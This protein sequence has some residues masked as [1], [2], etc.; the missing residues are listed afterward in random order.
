MREMDL[1][2]VDLNL[3][4]ALEALLEEKNVTRAAHRLGMSQPAASRALARLRS[5]FSDALLVDGPGGYVLSGRA[6]EL[7]P[8]LRRI[9]TNVSEML[10]ANAFVPATATGRVRLLMPDL[11]AVSLAPHLLVILAR[12]APSL[13]LDIVAPGANATE[14]LENGGADAMVALIDDAPPGIQRR[15]LYDET[16]V[17]LLRANHPALTEPLTLDRFLALDHIV[18]SV[19]GVG[20]VP[21]DE[22]L[23]RMGRM[24]RV[25]LR[26]PELLRGRRDRRP[27]G[28]RHDAAFQPGASGRQ[29]AALRGV[30]AARRPR[31]LHDEPRL[32]RPSAGR[33]TP[34]LAATRRRRGRR[35]DV[36]GARASRLSLFRRGRADG[37]GRSKARPFRSSAPNHQISGRSS[38]PAGRSSLMALSSLATCSKERSA[39]P[40]ERRPFS[41]RSI[42][43]RSDR[44]VTE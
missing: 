10:E 31:P 13:D 2:Q 15:G 8:V 11:Q 1:R 18:V 16:L 34:R 39:S 19:T 28:P 30:A 22:V 25:R 20:P 33:A 14:L 36:L 3:L 4:V 17:T 12:E 44:P 21:V 27:L 24:R 29:H 42:R 35:G 5:V 41:G 7:R 6:E 9:L 43:R 38:C 40:P 26:V 37:P 32:A 23:A